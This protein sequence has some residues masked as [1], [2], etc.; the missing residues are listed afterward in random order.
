MTKTMRFIKQ[1]AVTIFLVLAFPLSWFPWLLYSQGN[2]NFPPILPLGPLLAAL[3][4][5]PLVGGWAGVKSWLSSIF[6]WRV[7]LRWY[8]M[9]IGLPI[10]ISGA[11]AGANILL[12]ASASTAALPLSLSAVL[13]AL[14]DTFLWVGLGE[15][16]GWSGFAL[17]RLLRSRSFFTAVL[18][19]GLVRILWH[20]P[21]FMTGQQAWPIAVLL[22]PVQLIFTWIFIRSQGSTFLLVLSHCSQNVVG[23]LIFTALFTGTDQMRMVW[24]LVAGYV[25]TAVLLLLATGASLS[26]SSEIQAIDEGHAGALLSGLS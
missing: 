3:I 16:A 10:V 26:A 12:G 17:P 22:I 8:V 7:G 13:Y 15:E 24:L 4:V 2:G 18:I 14:L 23:G 20:L 5:V 6:R 19:M 1:H 21:L 11:A 9:A 25:V